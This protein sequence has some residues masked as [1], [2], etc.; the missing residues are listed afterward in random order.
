[1]EKPIEERC[2]GAGDAQECAPVLEWPVA[3]QPEAAPLIRG[4]DQAEEQ[5]STGLVE[6]CEPDLIDQNQIVAQYTV[7][8]AAD[9]VVGETA[10]E[11]FDQVGSGAIA[12]AQT[13]FDGM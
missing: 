7:D 12:H 8:D 13:L 1:M 9:G 3:G 11:L 4:G 6:R 10:I 2:R 5:L